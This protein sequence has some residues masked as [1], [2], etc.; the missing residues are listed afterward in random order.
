MTRRIP[1]PGADFRNRS[2]VFEFTD[3]LG[4]SRDDQVLRVHGRD[5]TVGGNAAFPRQSLVEI[6]LNLALFAPVRERDRGAGD[7]GKLRSHEVVGEIE[8]T[9]FR[10]RSA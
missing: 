9:L 7:A 8:Q 1:V 10:Y 5:D 2:I 3:L 6:D 4:A